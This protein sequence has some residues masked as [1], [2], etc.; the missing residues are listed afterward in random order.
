MVNSHDITVTK[1]ETVSRKSEQPWVHGTVEN[2]PWQS[3]KESL[4]QYEM[5]ATRT[6]QMA[7]TAGTMSMRSK[8]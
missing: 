1:D 4:S 6:P 7:Q 3:R 5:I 8:Q 2:Y